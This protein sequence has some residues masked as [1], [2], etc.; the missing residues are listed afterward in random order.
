MPNQLRTR[1]VQLVPI[2]NSKGIRIPKALIGKYGLKDTLLMEET[3]G[4]LLIR[5]K[6]KGKLSWAETYKAMA[7]EEESWEDFDETLA[8]GLKDEDFGD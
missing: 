5:N 6:E 3:E 2:G 1:D 8:D 7:G 4:G